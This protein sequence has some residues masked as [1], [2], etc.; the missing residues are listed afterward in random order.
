MRHIQRRKITALSLAIGTL[1]VFVSACSSGPEIRVE[2]SVVGAEVYH[3]KPGVQQP[4]KL[5]AAPLDLPGTLAQESGDGGILLRIQKE[6]YQAENLYLPKLSS[7]AYGTIRVNMAPSSSALSATINEVTH[8]IGVI[9]SLIGKRKFAEA[10]T[11]AVG[12]T[13][14]FPD[15]AIAYDLLGNIHYLNRRPKDALEAYKKSA[16][17][18]PRN[19]ETVRMVQKISGFS[20]GGGSE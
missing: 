16:Q 4:V 7:L 15:L 5:G 10:E 13:G 2:S 14:K 3:V 1:G 19:P 6:G 17:I 9:Y 12:L 20:G 11:L 8:Q 18:N